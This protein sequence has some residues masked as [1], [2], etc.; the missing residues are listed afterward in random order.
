MLEQHYSFLEERRKKA[1]YHYSLAQHW[2]S[3]LKQA[4]LDGIDPKT[5]PEYYLLVGEMG[6]EYVDDLLESEI[7]QFN[8]TL[9]DES[10]KEKREGK[11]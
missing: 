8:L 9:E 10:Q 2:I 5:L 11:I 3:V 6:D 1:M 7:I 4:C